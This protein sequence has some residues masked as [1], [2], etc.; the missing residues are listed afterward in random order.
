[1]SGN[2]QAGVGYAIG[3]STQLDLSWRYLYLARD[4]GQSS[5]TAYTI[6]Q[7]GIEIGVKVFF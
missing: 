2:A 3:N 6:D 1:M 5:S 4:N 7:N